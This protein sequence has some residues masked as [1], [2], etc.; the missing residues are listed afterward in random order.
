MH[1]NSKTVLIKL[2]IISLSGASKDSILEG[3]SS[4]KQAARQ[5]L[6]TR[7]FQKYSQD[8]HIKFDWKIRA[9]ENT[10]Y[11]SMIGHKDNPF[12][13]DYKEAY[14]DFVASLQK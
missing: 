7:W 5:R 9:D 3:R 10:F 12:L 11:A 13:E 2:Q 8:L 6:F 4:F 14:S 1:S